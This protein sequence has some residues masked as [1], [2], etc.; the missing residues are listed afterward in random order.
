VVSSATIGLGLIVVGTTITV[1][2]A[3]KVLSLT[4]SR[5]KHLSYALCGVVL[6]NIGNNLLADSLHDR[7]Q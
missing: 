1:I 7:L 6:F 5:R 3:D 2:H 4:D